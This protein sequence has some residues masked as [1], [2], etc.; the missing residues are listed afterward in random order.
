M[1]VGVLAPNVDRMTP[2]GYPA[3]VRATAQGSTIA[4]TERR[5]VPGGTHSGTPA[6]RVSG[7]RAA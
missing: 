6:R 4:V 5:G 2:N 3:V 7:G 1:I